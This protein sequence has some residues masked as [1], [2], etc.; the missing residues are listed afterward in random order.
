MEGI[1]ITVDIKTISIVPITICSSLGKNNDTAVMQITHA[2]G[3]TN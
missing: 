3:L 1:F 2:L